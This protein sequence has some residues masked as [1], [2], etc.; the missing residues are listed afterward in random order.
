MKRDEKKQLGVGEWLELEQTADSRVLSN[1]Y[2]NCTKLT[3]KK[4]IN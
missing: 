3:V 4:R 2:T 1:S